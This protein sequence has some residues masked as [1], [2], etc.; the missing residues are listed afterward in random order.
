MDLGSQVRYLGPS[1]SLCREP[2]K[3]SECCNSTYPC[4]RSVRVLQ[5]DRF[6]ETGHACVVTESVEQHNFELGRQENNPYGGDTPDDKLSWQDGCYHY[7]KG[8]EQ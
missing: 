5:P 4:Q 7:S 8:N 1:D 3:Q 2:R 6:K